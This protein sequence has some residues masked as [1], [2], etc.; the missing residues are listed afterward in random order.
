[1][2][3]EGSPKT[4][5]LLAEIEAMRQEREEILV[6]RKKF[7]EI[8]RNHISFPKNIGGVEFTPTTSL[9]HVGYND[10]VVDSHGGIRRLSPTILECVATLSDEQKIA[11]IIASSGYPFENDKTG[12]LRPVNFTIVVDKLGCTFDFPL[13]GGARIQKENQLEE[14]H[15]RILDEILNLIGDPTTTFHPQP[16]TIGQAAIA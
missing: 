7:G 5:I 4:P 10:L 3:K 9:E 11:I 16:Y 13:A 1:M 6:L 14:R 2:S 8:I 15:M 12:E